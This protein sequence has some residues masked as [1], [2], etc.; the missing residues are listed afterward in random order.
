MQVEPG[1]SADPPTV[2]V[3]ALFAELQPAVRGYL[4]R[5]LPPRVD[6][7]VVEDL[8]ADTFVRALRSAGAYRDEGKPL[9][10]LLAIAHAVLVDRARAEAGRRPVAL[11]V[12]SERAQAIAAPGDA[13]ALVD[14]R[15]WIDELLEVLPA[16][17]RE[18]LVWRYVRDATVSRTAEA[19]GLT[20][21]EVRRLQGL[22]L[23]GLRRQLRRDRHS[24]DAGPRA[25]ARAA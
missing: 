24:A 23:A 5:R 1:R 18:V 17:Q 9:A 15:L 8:V 3:G 19:L 6:D 13:T 22:A 7:A 14:G 16:P 2:D 12:V 11:D 10:W 21:P 20:V 25:G 4:R